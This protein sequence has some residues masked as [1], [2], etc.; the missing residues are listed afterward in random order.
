[1]WPIH[2]GNEMG[3]QELDGGTLNLTNILYIDDFACE[4]ERCISKWVNQS[5]HVYK[6]SKRQVDMLRLTGV[7][8]VT[9]DRC[10][11]EGHANP[12]FSE[13]KTRLSVT[14]IISARWFNLLLQR[15]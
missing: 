15:Q 14:D 11:L 9:V 7:V 8:W 1:M 6:H 2:F 10:L 3:S 12:K 5:S 4:C 13:L